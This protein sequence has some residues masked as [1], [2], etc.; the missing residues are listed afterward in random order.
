[1]FNGGSLTLTNSTVSGNSAGKGGG[2]FNARDG[3]Y[4]F[5]VLSLSHTVVSGNT[6]SLR[7]RE[8][9]IQSH[10]SNSEYSPVITDNFNVFGRNGISGV[11]GFTPGPTDI[12]PNLALI[13]ILDHRLSDNGGPTLTHALVFGS[14]AVDAVPATFC[15]TA[16]DQRGITRPQDDDGNGV[17]DC[18]IGAFE[19]A[20]APGP[21][22][23][24]EAEAPDPKI[25]CTGARCRV[26]VSCNLSQ[27]SGTGCT[28]RITLFVRASTVR[29]SDK[30]SAK[31]RR[32]IRFSA[33][34]ANVP[35]GQ[36]KFVKL[37]LTK[38]GRDL[39]K[40]KKRLR[41]VMEIRNTPGTAVST[42]PITI[43]LK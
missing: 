30:V 35:P 40:G 28:N 22:P 18:D 9:Y 16:T 42:I 11:Q 7:G 37:K 23:L 32:R 12:V 1:M 31:T 19:G 13:D 3:E 29:L 36:T 39:M 25:P 38:R 4:S 43:R 33:G 15:A 17:A 26:L 6:A 2:V 20:Q 34:V 5:G 27:F 24:V 41:G 8:V 10:S 21:P 14:P